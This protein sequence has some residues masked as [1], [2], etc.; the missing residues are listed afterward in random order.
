MQHTEAQ[1][2]VR[3]KRD[4][5]GDVLTPGPVGGVLLHQVDSPLPSPPTRQ[6]CLEAFFDLSRLGCGCEPAKPQEEIKW[7]KE[8]LI[9]VRKGNRRHTKAQE[10]ENRI[11]G[12][13]TP[14]V[15]VI[16]V[17]WMAVGRNT[18]ARLFSF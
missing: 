9:N 7:N 6:Q 8:N 11:R 17:N 12:E 10:T 1:T 4:P 2:Q 13:D 15:L 5:E 14:T 16:T 3:D 18:K